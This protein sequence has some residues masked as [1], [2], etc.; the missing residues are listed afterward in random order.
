M[1][2]TIYKPLRNSPK[3]S[4]GNKQLSVPPTTSSIT[5]IKHTKAFG[6]KSIG[7]SKVAVRSGKELLFLM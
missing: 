6:I 7:L 4:R 1:L 5:C 2:G 3:E